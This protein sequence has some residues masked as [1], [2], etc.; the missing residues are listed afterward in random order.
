MQVALLDSF[1]KSM[2]PTHCSQ[3]QKVQRFI[4]QPYSPYMG[5]LLVCVFASAHLRTYPSFPLW[6][7]CSVS[8]QS[9]TA[10]LL[11]KHR[12]WQSAG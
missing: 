10:V 12:E 8:T 5:Y 1:S 7:D 9:T 4:T 2:I 11:S 3:F 6:K